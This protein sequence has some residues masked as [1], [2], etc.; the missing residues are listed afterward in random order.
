M[1]VSFVSVVLGGSLSGSDE[2]T[3]GE[4]RRS[5]RTTNLLTDVS[6][7]HQDAIKEEKDTLEP[8]P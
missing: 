1:S 6:L 4:P 5:G 8:T 2:K 3:R 7:L